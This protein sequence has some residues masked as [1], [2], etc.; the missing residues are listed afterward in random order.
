MDVCKNNQLIK[1]KFECD[2]YAK[3]LGIVLD[4]L[5]ESSI[6]MHMELR[7]DMENLYNRPHGGVIYSLADAAFSIIANNQN[8]ISVALDCTITYHNG[9]RTGDMLYVHGW[10]LSISRK[11][12]SYLFD[13]YT[14]KNDEKT[15]IAT[16]KGTAYRTGYKIEKEK[17]TD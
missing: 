13:V 15:P 11:V 10:T 8:N 1:N 3:N 12:S 9:P 2:N 16:M 7:D 17:E 6:R 14:L 5:T 4:E